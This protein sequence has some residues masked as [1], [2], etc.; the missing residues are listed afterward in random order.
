MVLAYLLLLFLGRPREVWSAL[1]LAALVILCL[2]PLRLYAVSFQ[3]SFVAVAAL[4]YFLPRWFWGAGEG[5]FPERW[6][7]RWAKR[8]WLRVKEAAA[9]SLVATLATA[10]LV[11][12]YFQVVPLL[13]VA[14]N[15]AAIP[16][17]LILALPLGEAAV[18]AECLHLAP[19]A[20]GL[21]YLG[22]F[23][24]AGVCGH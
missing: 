9:V 12:A 18:W 17:V 4:L 13:G 21:L 3:L 11:A 6:A 2:T 5:L 8:V 19:V 23:P 10:P 16:L 15:L 14:V 7:G 1:A 24:G 22:N 20:K